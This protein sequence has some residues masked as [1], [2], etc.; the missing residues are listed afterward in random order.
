MASQLFFFYL[1]HTN[2]NIPSNEYDTKSDAF[3][4]K[5]INSES[6]FYSS[7]KLTLFFFFFLLLLLRESYLDLISCQKWF[8]VLYIYISQLS[9][10]VW[11]SSNRTIL[12]M[13]ILTDLKRDEGIYMIKNFNNKKDIVLLDYSTCLNNFSSDSVSWLIRTCSIYIYIDILL[14]K[15]FVLNLY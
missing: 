7:T 13:T 3:F 2:H 8:L 1:A 14:T 10:S 4:L 5:A 9:T 11:N 12:I 15:G 6:I